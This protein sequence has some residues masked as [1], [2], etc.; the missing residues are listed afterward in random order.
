MATDADLASV[1]SSSADRRAEA[2]QNEI[3][4]DKLNGTFRA[5]RSG[6]RNSGVNR[7]DRVDSRAKNAFFRRASMRRACG[8]T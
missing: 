1:T 2:R 8:L 7:C 5:G 6:K 4:L 3:D